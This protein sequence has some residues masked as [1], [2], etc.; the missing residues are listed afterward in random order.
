MAGGGGGLVG[1]GAGFVEFQFHQAN[2]VI[3]RVLRSCFPGNPCQL[4]QD[5]LVIAERILGLL[6]S[7]DADKIRVLF[8]SGHQAPGFF[9]TGPNEPH[10]IARTAL[11]AGS[12]IFVNLDHLYTSEG[13]AKLTFAQVAGLVTHE[14]G[15]Q[16]GILDHQTLDRLGSRVSEIVQ[17]QSLLYSYS[18]ELGGLGFQLGVTNFDFPATI[19]LIV[20]YANDR[21]RNFST[22]IT[23]MVSCQRP[24]FQM[25]GYSLTNG[26]FSL[27]GNMSDPKDSNIGFEAWLRVNC[28]N[29]AE[30]RFL[31]ELHKLV[32][33]VNDQRELQTLT[34]TPLK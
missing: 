3:D 15:H 31:S 34:V 2:H 21:T 7:S 17:G 12:P 23:R 29:Q 32:I 14:L 27:Q 6:R 26:H 28:F 8:L 22:S 13:L 4:D 19:P 9:N 30:D 1:N 24:E 20:L 11:E 5:L 25:T 33:L 10:R 18:G 16:I